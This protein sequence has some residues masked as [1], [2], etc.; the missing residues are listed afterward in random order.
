MSRKTELR[1][2]IE[3]QDSQEKRSCLDTKNGQKY[4][5]GD[6]PREKKGRFYA[7]ERVVI[8]TWV[9][10]AFRCLQFSCVVSKWK[11]G[12]W[13][14]TVCCAGPPHRIWNTAR[15]RNSNG[16]VSDGEG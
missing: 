11:L 12:R 15:A 4:K 8:Y 10:P 16:L 5:K 6:T 1:F 2:S 3:A 7:G 9:L 13:E 14:G